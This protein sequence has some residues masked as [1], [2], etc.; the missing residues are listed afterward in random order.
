M[1]YPRLI[2]AVLCLTLLAAACSD[3][4]DGDNTINLGESGLT[5]GIDDIQG[6]AEGST[7]GLTFATLDNDPASFEQYLGTP[8]VINFF[9][10]WCPNC[11]EEM[12]EF[13]TVFQDVRDEINF[14]GISL[15]QR[16]EEAIDLIKATG[17]T[18]DIGWDPAEELFVHFRGF[19]YPTTVFVDAEGNVA[20][21]W[22]GVL[23][24]D[25][26]RDRINEELL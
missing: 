3:D 20:R 22:S 9:A 1:R 17:V 8:L 16:P 15:D 12:P 10:Q 21:V 6:V 4:G 25:T 23:D 5:P 14:I 26:L 13:E 24:E 18:Y 11:V 7:L 2:A 19:S